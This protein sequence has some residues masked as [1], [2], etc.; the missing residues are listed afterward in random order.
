MFEAR[1]KSTITD[2]SGP[3]YMTDEQITAYLKE[4]RSSRA[5]RP[6][7]SR[8][9]PAKNPAIKPLETLP[10]HWPSPPKVTSEVTAPTSQHAASPTLTTFQRSWDSPNRRNRSDVASLSS[11]SA[12]SSILGPQGHTTSASSGSPTTSPG[13]TYQERSQRLKE[14]QEAR[15]IRE[16]MERLKLEHDAEEQRLYDAAQTEAAELVLKHQTE[17]LPKYQPASAYRNPDLRW[18]RLQRRRGNTMHS[19]AD[20]SGGTSD[21]DTATRA[22]A[23]REEKATSQISLN[24]GYK[25]NRVEVHDAQSSVAEKSA[26]DEIKPLSFS[27]IRGVHKGTG[28]ETTLPWLNRR[29]QSSG[30]GKRIGSNSSSKNVSGVSR[31]SN[32][33]SENRPSRVRFGPT[34]ESAQPRS[35]AANRAS[36]SSEK[37]PSSGILRNKLSLFELHKNPPTQSKNPQY[38]QNPAPEVAPAKQRENGYEASMPSIEIRSEEIRAA[39]SMRRKDRSPRLP[40]PTAVSDSSRRP[41]VSFQEG[42]EAPKKEANG[43]DNES[44]QPALMIKPPSSVP[45]VTITSEKTVPSISISPDDKISAAPTPAHE[46]ARG[47]YPKREI[48]AKPMAAPP[49]SR[50]A[51]SVIPTI[52]ISEKGDVCN[53]TVPSETLPR[54]G[55]RTSRPLPNPDLNNTMGRNNDGLDSA[56]TPQWRTPYIRTGVPAAACDSCHKPI[57]GR[58]VTACNNR[59]HPHCFTCYHCHTPL[60]CVA[61]Y[62]EPEAKRQERLAATTSRDPETLMQ[63][64]YCHLDFHELFSPR[65]KSCKTPIEGEVVVACGAQYHVGHFF[66]AECGDP[67]SPTTPF[68]EKDG[69]AWCVGCH[70]RRT[71]PRCMGCKQLVMDDMIINALGGSWH[72]K[73][74]KC[75]EC[76]ETISHESGFFVREGPPKLTSKGRQIGGPVKNPVCER[77]EACRLKS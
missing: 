13:L 5:S 24:D 27:K 23:P 3:T 20:P 12:A 73:C 22:S 37:C 4:L 56:T 40:V 68:I 46:I 50:S 6:A 36:R 77:C 42:W 31:S 59:F 64:F 65:C 21:R 72:S 52:N 62:Q 55:N 30:R 28:T 9:L 10:K 75:C 43:A 34:T 33:G 47:G 41:I 63:R 15:E 11:S 49:L 2:M 70:S 1:E 71:S 48:I 67:F 66:C 69:H 25:Y 74:F 18:R 45:Q 58:V 61:F 32:A 39:T 38:T 8:P 7:G 53:I 44:T 54:S 35:W 19:K 60:E 26:R 14:R 29:R 16:A 17:G 76:G 57:A 51:P